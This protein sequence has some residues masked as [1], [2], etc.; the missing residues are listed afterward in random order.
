DVAVQL[1]TAHDGATDVRRFK[2]DVSGRALQAKV[3]LVA[4]EDQ[5]Q[6]AEPD[7]ARA[8][9]VEPG[10]QAGLDH[11]AVIAAQPCSGRNFAAAAGQLDF[12]G[13]RIAGAR[14]IGQHRSLD[15]V[16]AAAALGQP[17]N[18][19]AKLLR[20]AGSGHNAADFAGQTQGFAEACRTR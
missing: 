1:G 11:A 8:V 18:D 4:L 6:V 9:F 20:A 19:V 17:D 2:R 12:I 16:G 3:E 14:D 15:A 10:P 7:A 5:A 13:V